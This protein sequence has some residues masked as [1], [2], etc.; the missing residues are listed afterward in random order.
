MLGRHGYDKI[1]VMWPE[2][3]HYGPYNIPQWHIISASWNAGS[4]WWATSLSYDLGWTEKLSAAWRARSWLVALKYAPRILIACSGAWWN[5]AFIDY[6]LTPYSSHLIPNTLGHLLGNAVFRKEVRFAPFIR[7]YVF[8]DE[9]K[10]PVTAIWS[11]LERVDKGLVNAPAAEIDFGNT[12]EG[13]YDLMNNQ[14]RFEPG[15]FRFA[16]SPFP[17]F[18]RGK[19]GT[20]DKMVTALNNTR[21]VSGEG[22]SPLGV[23]ANPISAD[24]YAVTVKNYLSREFTGTFNGKVFKLPGT[25]N[26]VLEMPLQPPLSVDRIN[27]YH[28]PGELAAEGSKFK[29]DLSFNAFACRKI[30]DNCS[31]EN[32]DWSTLP[33]VKFT[34]PS[35]KKQLTSGFFRC[36]WNVRGFFIEVEV[37]DAHFVHTEFKRTSRR[38]NNDCLQ[39]YFDTLCDARAKGQHQYNE[40]DYDYAVFPNAKGDSSI[41]FRYRSVDP[42]LGLATQAPPDNVVAP[43]IPSSFRR[44]GDRSL[45]RVFFP[46][47]YLMPL[48]L[49]A[50]SLF[51]FGLYVPNVDDVNAKKNRVVSALSLASNGGGCYDRPHLWPALLLTDN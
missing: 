23:T 19:P 8:E 51:G 14:R 45:Y 31:F 18:F 39:I 9:A 41:V 34:D 29:L 37:K 22:I 12:L 50:G 47:R 16:V 33:A 30:A 4:C 5:N 20:L 32:L 26:T 13:V 2:M 10:R 46:A 11:Y 28:L 24:K 38:W 17:V 35:G 7:A 25:G 42:Q 49:K 43:D 15:K 3:M 36:G 21:L 1:P 48:N 40:N 27:S 44:E 6:D